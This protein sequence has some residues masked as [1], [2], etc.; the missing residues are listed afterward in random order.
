[1]FLVK[2]RVVIFL[3]ATKLMKKLHRFVSCSQ[4]ISRYVDI[5]DHAETIRFL[6]K[7]EKVLAKYKEI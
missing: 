3:S 7:D 6:I 4:K 5:F 2:K 1:M